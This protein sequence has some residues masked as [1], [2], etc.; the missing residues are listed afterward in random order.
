[1]ILIW[2]SHLI[3]TLT[4]ISTIHLNAKFVAKHVDFCSNIMDAKLAI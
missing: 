1:M 4:N 3:G 2:A